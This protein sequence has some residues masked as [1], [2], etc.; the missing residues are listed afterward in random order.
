MP[1]RRETCLDC[2]RTLTSIQIIDKKGERIAPH[3]VLEY[4]VS[5][6]KRSKWRGR[7]PV[8]GRVHAYMCDACGRVLLY[9]KAAAFK[10]Y[11]FRPRP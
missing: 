6:A 10:N 2:N 3:G 5:D 4:A 11:L 7:F 9:A 8:E 1:A